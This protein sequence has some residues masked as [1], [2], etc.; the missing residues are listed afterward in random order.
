[1]DVLFQL[2]INEYHGVESLQL[3]LPDVGTLPPRSVKRR[4]RT[5]GWQACWQ[6]AGFLRS[7]GLLPDRDD[8]ARVYACLRER[9]RNGSAPC[10]QGNCARVRLLP[11]RL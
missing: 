7:E 8:V 9:V 11:E 2:G 1:M 3:I 6:A 5:S 10:V 4:R